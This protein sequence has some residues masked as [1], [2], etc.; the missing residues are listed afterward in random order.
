MI[1]GELGIT[2]LYIDI[3]TRI[4]SFW[5]KLIDNESDK[6]SSSIYKIVL[7]LHNS[8]IFMSPWIK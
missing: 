8:Q 7:E 1:Y 4:V 5:S 2:P 6:L 3:Q